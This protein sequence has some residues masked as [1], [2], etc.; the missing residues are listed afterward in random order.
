MVAYILRFS[1][2]M[3]YECEHCGAFISGKSY[4]VTS[5]ESGIKLLDMIVCHSC[6]IESQK[7]GLQAE[8]MDS[9]ALVRES[10][11]RRSRSLRHRLR[12]PLRSSTPTHGTR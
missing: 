10:R 5:V 4:R 6:F 7:L 8:E 11:S 9:S 1:L 3:T 2:V 12:G